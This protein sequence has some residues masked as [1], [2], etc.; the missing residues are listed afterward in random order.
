MINALLK[1]MWAIVIVG[2]LGLFP[3]GAFTAGLEPLL[4][5][6]VLLGVAVLAMHVG[7]HLLPT[8]WAFGIVTLLFSAFLFMATWEGVKSVATPRTALAPE[9]AKSQGGPG[10]NQH[11]EGQSQRGVRQR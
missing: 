11:N 7:I 10:N 4:P 8:H 1:L 2:I 3:V 5:L 6:I 9:S